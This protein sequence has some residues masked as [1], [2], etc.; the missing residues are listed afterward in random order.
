VEIQKNPLS[1]IPLYVRIPQFLGYLEQLVARK[2]MVIRVVRVLVVR[3]HPLPMMPHLQPDHK[4]L[5][6][7]ATIAIEFVFPRQMLDG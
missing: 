4:V 2:V 3:F 1:Y 6:D 5:L 7:R